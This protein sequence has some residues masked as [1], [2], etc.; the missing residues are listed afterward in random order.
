MADD[1]GEF[2]WSDLVQVGVNEYVLMFT[3]RGKT[4]EIKLRSLH[5]R[6]DG[7]PDRFISE[8]V[9][10]AKFRTGKKLHLAAMD[11]WRVKNTDYYRPSVFFISH[12]NNNAQ[13]IAWSEGKTQANS[14]WF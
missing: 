2:R 11:F 1:T 9:F 6:E 12:N 14:L 5:I 13:I 8:Y 3:F 7:Y 10:S 4:K